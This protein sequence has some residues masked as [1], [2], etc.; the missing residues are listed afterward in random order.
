MSRGDDRR[1]IEKAMDELHA[2]AQG[3]QHLDDAQR[4]ERAQE[5]MSRIVNSSALGESAEKRLD[6]FLKNYARSGR[7]LDFTGVKELGIA[8]WCEG[9]LCGNVYQR[10]K[11]EGE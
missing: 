10:A 1:R 9:F 6:A 2:Y 8:M 4:A 5:S 7:Q 3:A 11:L